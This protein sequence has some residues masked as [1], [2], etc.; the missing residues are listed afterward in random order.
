MVNGRLNA[1]TWS[2][3]QQAAASGLAVFFSDVMSCL[4][5]RLQLCS[6]PHEPC[7]SQSKA[8]A[9]DDWDIASTVPAFEVEVET[10]R[11]E[12]MARNLMT[13]A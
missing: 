12:T 8:T 9:P 2:H 3:V 7:E 13:E 4:S 10:A 5:F 6:M 11:Q 1:F